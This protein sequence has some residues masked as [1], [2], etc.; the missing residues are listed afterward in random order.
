MT[1]ASCHE[2]Q[3]GR[4]G[5]QREQSLGLY[6]T[7]QIDIGGQKGYNLPSILN[8]AL[9]KE[10]SDGREFGASFVDAKREV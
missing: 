2:G 6:T 1:Y 5:R 9:R 8:D 10:R 4:R 7:C 3:K